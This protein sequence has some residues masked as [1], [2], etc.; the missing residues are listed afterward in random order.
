MQAADQ[1]L[2]ELQTFRIGLRMDREAFWDEFDQE[3]AELLLEK[4]EID[5]NAEEEVQEVV[6]EDEGR[7]IVS[8]KKE[9]QMKEFE[10][11]V[12]DVQMTKREEF[13][14][15]GTDNDD[16]VEVKPDSTEELSGEVNDD[17]DSNPAIV[18]PEQPSVEETT[19]VASPLVH[20]E[21]SS[22]PFPFHIADLKSESDVAKAQE[23]NPR[24]PDEADAGK[25]ITSPR[26]EET[27]VA[28]SVAEIEHQDQEQA[29][30][31]G[32]KLDSRES[33][34]WL[35]D[36]RG[37][38]SPSWRWP[39]GEGHQVEAKVNDHEIAAA[40]EEEDGPPREIERDT[41]SGLFSSR[42]ASA[43]EVS[44]GEEN[45]ADHAMNTSDENS[46]PQEPSSVP[47]STQ[48][49]GPDGGDVKIEDTADQ[50]FTASH[51]VHLQEQ[52]ASSLASSS[53]AVS[54]DI[55]NREAHN[56]ADSSSDASNISS[57]PKDSSSSS[58]GES[59]AGEDVEGPNIMQWCPNVPRVPQDT[60]LSQEID[61]STEGVGMESPEENRGGIE[62]T[63]ESN[64]STSNIARLLE[65]VSLPHD[66]SS[67][68]TGAPLG[69]VEEFGGEP[70]KEAANQTSSTN[71]PQATSP[72]AS[73][74]P[75]G[76]DRGVSSEAEDTVED[77]A[78]TAP[79]AASLPQE[80][81]VGEDLQATPA[82]SVGESPVVVP[83]V[84]YIK[85]QWEESLF[86]PEEPAYT[87]NDYS[88]NEIDDEDVQDEEFDEVDDREADDIDP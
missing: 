11:E 28:Q 12:E 46:A 19:Q 4:T 70:E 45:K 2:D 10:A 39:P 60:S 23:R 79:G 80:S 8:E 31:A 88:A 17:S 34:P 44:N 74:I 55:I 51:T 48:P 37:S 33:T 82:V 66:T 3:G 5:P 13:N 71:P 78:E 43:E 67:S 15:S 38:H 61:P 25:G 75:S 62:D 77:H 6:Q 24:S 58:S 52:D 21:E 59:E 35:P 22:P 54:P 72:T 57:L 68:T 73:G 53:R 56:S 9:I 14:R 7:D 63:V 26:Q 65:E 41:S 87:A 20:N 42:S 18:R 49:E 50:T 32:E 1:L 27:P 40:V 85:P 30:E 64:S 47:S 83:N 69:S 36:K 76:S 86:S 16:I 84:R 81:S 29:A